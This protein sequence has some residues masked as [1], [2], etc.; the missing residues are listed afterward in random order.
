MTAYIATH[1]K[2]LNIL[3]KR[4]RELIHALKHG[5]T[6]ERLEKAAEKL[7]IAQLAMFKAKF[8][9]NSALPP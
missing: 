1:Q 3:H 8:T 5:Y 7:R 6:Q 4:E 9:Q 2:K